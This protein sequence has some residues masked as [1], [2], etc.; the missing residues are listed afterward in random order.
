MMLKIFPCL[1]GLMFW[2]AAA[3]KPP[4]LLR[5]HLQAP[6]GAK[7]Q[8]SIPVTLFDP[9][10][11]I[12]IRSLPEVTEKDIRRV[13]TRL[14]GTSMV[15]FND[16]GRTKLEVATSTSRGLILVVIVNSRVVYAPMIDMAISKGALILP[17]GA[18]SGPEEVAF[19]EQANKKR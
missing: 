3:E 5:V 2:I 6:E 4:A 18:I 17:A 9:A 15:E 10:E 8:V 13:Q 19:N 16:F 1:V 14:D 12:A 7:G 11:T